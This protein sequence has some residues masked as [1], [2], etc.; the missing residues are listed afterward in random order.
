MKEPRRTYPVTR[1]H[2]ELSG[3]AP[4][5]PVKSSDQMTLRPGGRGTAPAEARERR[6]IMLER[7][8]RRI[9]SVGYIIVK[10]M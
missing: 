3:R 8:E 9:L 1:F 2:F 7:I 5:A 6:G 10:K 4:A